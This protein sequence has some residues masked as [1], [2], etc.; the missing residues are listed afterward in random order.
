MC[1]LTVFTKNHPYAKT[2]HFKK[3]QELNLQGCTALVVAGT[4]AQSPD[5]NFTSRLITQGG[6]L[7][8]ST[9]KNTYR[10]EVDGAFMYI[11]RPDFARLDLGDALFKALDAENRELTE[12][13]LNL[14]NT[15]VLER[16]KRAIGLII[17]AG[18]VP[19]VEVV[20]T[21]KSRPLGVMSLLASLAGCDLC[22]I[23]RALH[24]LR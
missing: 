4:V 6:F 22:S 3:G 21:K 14:A 9:V 23:S 18:I 1:E 8:L 13:L 16:L 24:G 20:L 15:T 11:P 10:G 12:A 5:R 2:K 7:N 19:N 17:K